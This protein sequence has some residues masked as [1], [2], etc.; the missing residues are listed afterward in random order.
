MTPPLKCCWNLCEAQRIRQQIRLNLFEVASHLN[1]SH[2]L[3]S[4][5][6][7]SSS[8]PLQVSR[9]RANTWAH[10]G[11]S[12]LEALWREPP[13]GRKKVRHGIAVFVTWFI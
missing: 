10:Q 1:I 9:D 4:P 7:P 6:L 12:S 13:F 5:P 11:R 8:S 3:P 2:L